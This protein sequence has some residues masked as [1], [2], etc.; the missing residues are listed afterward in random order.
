MRDQLWWYVARATGVTTWVLSAASVLWGMAL[1]TRALGKRPRAPWLLD[2]HRYL[3]GLSVVFLAVHLV[4]LTADSYTEFGLADLLVP[5]SSS[6]QPGA[7]AWG[8]VTMYL[9]LAVEITSLLSR[10]VPKLWWRRVHLLSYLVFALGTIHL[11]TAGSDASSPALRY[12]VL[13]V[14]AAQAF[15]F[16]YLLAGPKRRGAGASAVAIRAGGLRTS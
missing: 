9:L 15:F 6:W 3:G 8:I 1:S 2:L 12:L 11:L 13:L 7:V 4:G 5:L 16:V 10:R 14:V